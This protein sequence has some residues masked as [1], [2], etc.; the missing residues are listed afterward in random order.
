LLEPLDH[1]IVAPK[2]VVKIVY[3]YPPN[4]QR[5]H[6]LI[7]AEY[8][9]EGGIKLKD[10]YYYK[11]E[12]YIVTTGPIL[13]GCRGDSGMIDLYMWYA[14]KMG[15]ADQKPVIHGTTSDAQIVGKK[16]AFLLREISYL[17]LLV[18][19]ASVSVAFLLVIIE[20]VTKQ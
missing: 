14:V 7:L 10:S 1:N 8:H 2:D 17:L 9:G 13:S 16:V 18:T 20:I 12:E 6:S 3:L 4:S 15:E 5:N 19:I 11:G